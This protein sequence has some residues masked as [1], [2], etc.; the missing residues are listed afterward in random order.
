[1]SPAPADTRP[2]WGN[3][4]LC[5]LLGAVLLGLM[6]LHAREWEW[7]APTASRWWWA[8]IV[9]VAWAG[10]TGWLGWH[11]RAASRRQAGPVTADRVSIS[12]TL[13][14]VFASQTGT[15]EQWA[16]QTAQS[17][18]QARVPARAVELGQIDVAMLTEARRVLFVVSTTGEGDAPDSAARFVTQCMHAPQTLASLQYGLLA[19]GDRDYNDFCGFG[20]ALQHWLQQS[21]ATPLFDPVEVDNGDPSALRH[22]QHH[23]ALLSGAAELPDWQA[24]DYR[25]WQLTER[26]LLNP[27]SAGGPCFHLALRPL[28][29]ET[30]WQAGDLVEIGPRHAMPAVDAWLATYGL[31]GNALVEH[32]GRRAA[33]REW[34]V[35]SHL[36]EHD[37]ARGKSLQQLAAALQAL[38]HREYSIASMPADGTLHL[39][40]RRMSRDDGS[41]GI[42][43]GWLTQYAQIGED[44][45][46][47]IRANPGFHMPADDRP[48]VLIGNGTGLAGLRALLKARIAA[49]RVRN[50]LLFGERDAAHDFYHRDEILSWQAQ[51]LIERIDLAWSRE[52]DSRDYVQDRL[53][54][55]GD[56]LQAWV[57]QGAAVYV[58]GSLAGMAPGVDAVLRD[59]LGDEAVERLRE[60]GRYRRDVY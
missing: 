59:R 22:W 21:G 45:A 50:W 1:M 28:E 12:E 41:P 54:R 32:A 2:A 24:P 5:S 6:A 48:M 34:L 36:P 16:R 29:G 39:L 31:D 53:R 8:C 46:L 56:V 43:S 60:E 37:Q 57:A 35:A 7:H 10:F 4:V 20:R 15:A 26:V 51:G 14:V 30:T 42:G 23:L 17:L 55:H 9:L 52:G 47:R 27:G 13:L 25:R 18:Q 44:I 38:P 19:L 40:V 58:C 49:G 11:R 3:I 33:L